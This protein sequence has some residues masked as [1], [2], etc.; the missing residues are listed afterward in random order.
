MPIYNADYWRDRARDYRE[1][2]KLSSEAE[3]KEFLMRFS[4]ACDYLA[5]DAEAAAAKNTA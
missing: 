1:K 3:A 2:A 4:A 5:E